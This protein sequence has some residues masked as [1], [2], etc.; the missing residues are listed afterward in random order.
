MSVIRTENLTPEEA[1]KFSFPFL[2]G[3]K[4]V[5][6]SGEQLSRRFGYEFTKNLEALDLSSNKWFG[7]IG[8][9]YGQH[10]VWIDEIELER[11]AVLSEVRSELVRDLERDAYKG[12]L[13]AELDKLRMKYEYMQ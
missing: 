12:V 2:P 9:T 8:S 10:L 4:F 1:R 5:R 7:P 13:A 3:Y 11:D 6:Q